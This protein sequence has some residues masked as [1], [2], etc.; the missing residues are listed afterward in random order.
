MSMFTCK[1]YNNM[2]KS[3]KLKCIYGR[4][5]INQLNWKARTYKRRKK[6]GR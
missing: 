2:K 1:Y 3:N 6:T 4:N 5:I